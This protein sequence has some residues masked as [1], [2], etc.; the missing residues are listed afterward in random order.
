MGEVACAKFAT[1]SS[2]QA[3]VLYGDRKIVS[4]DWYPTVPI[5]GGFK[6]V[7]DQSLDSVLQ[8]K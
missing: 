6:V 3:T 4:R 5:E 8:K 1:I 7:V 2:I